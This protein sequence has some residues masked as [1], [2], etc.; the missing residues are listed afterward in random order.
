M[1]LNH[2]DKTASKILDM[3]TGG[4]SRHTN[5][6]RKVGA[7]KN[8]LF[9]DVNINRLGN[10]AV[11][12]LLGRKYSV[13]HV[14]LDDARLLCSDPEMEFFHSRGLW[15]PYMLDRAGQIKFSI[16]FGRDWAVN[17]KLQRA[18][19]KFANV[20]MRNIKW[21]QKEYFKDFKKA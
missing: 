20:W 11:G 2:L 6:H 1:R 7:G 12:A 17:K 15:Y 16:I 8:S 9:M 5:T 3:L 18:H 13:S 4:L 10:D 19:T 21:Q 14:Y